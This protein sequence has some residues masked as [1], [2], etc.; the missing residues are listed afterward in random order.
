MQW[1]EVTPVLSRADEEPVASPSSGF[2]AKGTT[3][4]GLCNYVEQHVPGGL[5]AVRDRLSPE[6]AQFMSQTFIPLGWY[7]ILPL[8]PVA[9]AVA[10]IMNVS[11]AEYVRRQASWRAE[12]DLRGIYK[13]LL[14]LSSPE[15]V[16]RRFPNIYSQLYNFGRIEVLHIEKG[17][18]DS[19]A[20][21][22]PEPVAEWWMKATESYM[23]V[24]MTAA[25]AKGHR[26][27][28]RPVEPDGSRRGVSLVRVACCT[29]WQER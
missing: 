13:L 22:M 2:S 12:R 27:M 7:D 24:V 5:R 21:G 9:R 26:T 23:A 8:P 16:V 19:C 6:L 1:D 29:V 11:L 18:V 10:S 4:L 14:K 17:R 15:A 28:W 25:G 3:W 20:F